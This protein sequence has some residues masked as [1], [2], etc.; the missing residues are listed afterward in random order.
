MSASLLGITPAQ[1]LVREHED[2][3]DEL[4]RIFVALIPLATIAVLLRLCSR[5]IARIRLWWDDYMTVASL[6]FAVG[7]NAAFLLGTYHGLGKH[8]EFVGMTGMEYNLKVGA[9]LTR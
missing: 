6:I 1:E 2:R 9:S 5:R 3:T 7:L 4:R 8:A